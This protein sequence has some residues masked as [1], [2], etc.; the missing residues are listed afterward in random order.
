[1][2]NEKI[3]YLICKKKYREGREWYDDLGNGREQRFEWKTKKEEIEN[4]V[5]YVR[6]YYVYYVRQYYVRK[7]KKW[8]K[9]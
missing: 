9:K 1:M 3:E 5:Y 8:I 2:W 6:K 4:C 7:T